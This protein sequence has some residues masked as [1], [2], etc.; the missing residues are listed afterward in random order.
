MMDRTEALARRVR[1][2][3]G[4]HNDEEKPVTECVRDLV[5]LVDSLDA[6]V[7]TWERTVMD[8]VGEDGPAS[9]AAAVAG[10]KRRIDDVEDALSTALPYIETAKDDPAYRCQ[11]VAAVLKHVTGVLL[12]GVKS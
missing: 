12:S 8:A 4:K 3:L 5:A 10:L 7:C 6:N 9:V 11:R 2:A 1:D